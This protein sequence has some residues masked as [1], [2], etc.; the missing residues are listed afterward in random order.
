MTMAPERRERA[1]RWAL[2]PALLRVFWLTNSGVGVTEGLDD[3]CLARPLV[4]EVGPS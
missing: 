2:F 3:L 1:I 4:P